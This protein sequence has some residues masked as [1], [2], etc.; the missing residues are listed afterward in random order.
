MLQFVAEK[1][2]PDDKKARHHVAPMLYDGSADAIRL[3]RERKN[4][5]QAEAAKRGGVTAQQWSDY[6]TRSKRL[7]LPE[8]PIVLA[9]LDATKTELV[10]A[11]YEAEMGYYKTAPD[12]IREDAPRYGSPA[13]ASALQSIWVLDAERLPPEDRRAF[14]DFRLGAAATLSAGIQQ[15]ENVKD[16]YARRATSAEDRS[17]A[18]GK[19]RIEDDES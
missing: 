18:E 8:L 6:E 13:A 12:E 16:F 19:E 17:D 2:Q 7:G 1:K 10:S 15:A 11:K 14:E 9:G 5:R 3:I 4:L